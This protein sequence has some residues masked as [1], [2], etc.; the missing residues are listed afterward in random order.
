MLR[1]AFASANKKAV[2]IEIGTASY[3]WL[4]WR[5]VAACFKCL[6]GLGRV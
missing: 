4:A 3:Y 5:P 1:L 6:A 2:P